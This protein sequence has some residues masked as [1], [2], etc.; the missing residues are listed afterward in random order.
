M[1]CRMSTFCRK[2]HFKQIFPQFCRDASW[3]ADGTNDPLSCAGDK[4][5]NYQE[6]RC[7][8]SSLKAFSFWCFLKSKQ[9]W[10]D[11][12]TDSDTTALASRDRGKRKCVVKAKSY[13]TKV[14]KFEQIL[15]GVRDD[16][17]NCTELLVCDAAVNYQLYHSFHIPLSVRCGCCGFGGIYGLFRIFLLHPR[18]SG[19]VNIAVCER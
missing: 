13:V 9:R 3:A 11:Y 8:L 14:I 18:G 17:S 7:S 19:L 12:Q 16:D 6:A 10:K 1:A 4:S 5:K 2:R 15:W